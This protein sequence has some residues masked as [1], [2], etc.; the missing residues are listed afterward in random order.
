MKNNTP[1][2]LIILVLLIQCSDAGEVQPPIQVSADFTVS[3]TVIR[4]GENVTF[5]DLSKGDP[6]SW[7]WTFSGGE[8]SSSNEQSPTIR[9]DVPGSYKVSLSASNG[10]SVDNE[11]K[12][13]F[14][15][16]EVKEEP[17]RSFEPNNQTTF[18]LSIR[19][20]FMQS[21][22]TLADNSFICVGWT[23]NENTQIAT[24]NI[25]ITKFDNDLNHVWNKVIGGSRP[26]LVRDVIPTSD[27]GFLLSATTESSDG[28]IPKNNGS[29]DILLVKLS[30]NGNIEWTKT[31]GGSAYDGVNRNSIVELENGYAFV[32][33][34]TSDD[35][36][37]PG[38]IGS[39]DI[40]L[41][42]IDD[43]GNITK[44]VAIGS[45]ENDFHY[46]FVKSNSGYVVLSKIGAKTATFDK[47]GVWVFEV[48]SDG[49]ISW[50]TFVD[51]TNAGRLIKTQDGGYV[52]INTD[53]NSLPDLFVTK[54]TSQGSVQWTKYYPLPNQEFAE[55]ILQIENEYIILGSSELFGGTPRNGNAYVAKL[56]ASGDLIQSVTF[57]DNKVSPCR[58]FKIGEQTYI[59]GGTKNV[60]QSFIDS[61]FWLQLISEH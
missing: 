41:A 11:I 8:P 18:G 51:A 40:W 13:N 14:I 57:G 32:G 33:Y 34:T 48:N 19:S 17:V 10:S 59:V 16:V 31:Y 43:N 52:T 9:Y 23:D 42:E 58:I 25:L 1:K 55:D 29:G 44:S 54:L 28:D 46:S 6:N 12:D 2:F 35:A 4:A 30:A 38:R 61:Q 21:M 39:T 60:G 53:K 24:T 3:H 49:N 36:G 47:P 56:N 20:D 7:N 26:D 5:T 45:T 15:S 37:I 50:K 22:I 27:G